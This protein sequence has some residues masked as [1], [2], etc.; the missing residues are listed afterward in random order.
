MH[1]CR[2]NHLVLDQGSL[3]KYM[4]DDMR[5]QAEY[6]E[7]TYTAIIGL[8]GGIMSDRYGATSEHYYGNI[9][10][11][12]HN[13][14]YDSDDPSREEVIAALNSLDEDVVLWRVAANVTGTYGS[15]TRGDSFIMY[16]TGEPEDAIE[17]PISNEDPGEI[18]F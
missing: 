14:E 15:Y 6:Y 13:P 2:V 4:L 17:I 16:C 8:R 18:V 12:G 7:F 3:D 11:Q 1:L 10:T 5:A 9:L